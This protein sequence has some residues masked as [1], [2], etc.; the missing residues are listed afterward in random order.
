MAQIESTLDNINVL[1]SPHPYGDFEF[2]P[3]TR[4]FIS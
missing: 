1:T 2:G 3:N 4:H